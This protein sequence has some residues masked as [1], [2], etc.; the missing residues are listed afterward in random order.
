MECCKS[1]AI[2]LI[3][4]WMQWKRRIP[5]Q[6]HAMLTIAGRLG[7]YLYVGIAHKSD[8]GHRI[9][10][11]MEQRRTSGPTGDDY[12]ADFCLRHKPTKVLLVW[13]APNRAVECYIFNS[14]RHAWGFGGK[15]SCQGGGGLWMKYIFINWI[16]F[17]KQR[18]NLLETNHILEW[19]NHIFE[20]NNWLT[21]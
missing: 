11:E 1:A 15:A 18:L 6:C 17:L 21:R 10:V 8:I 13:P 4:G 7:S 16:R 5:N 19:K 2:S 14:I 3:W 20:A 12:C 9:A